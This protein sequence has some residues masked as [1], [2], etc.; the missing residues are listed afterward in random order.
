M[1]F[2][3]DISSLRLVLEYTRKNHIE[4]YIIGNGT[5]L[6]INECF[7]NKIF[8]NLKQLNKIECLKNNK[9]LILAGCTCPK[10]ACELARKG[11]VNQEFLS[12][13]PGS[14][15]G[16]IYMNA[17]AYGS[18]VSK[19]IDSVIILDKNNKI[20]LIKNTKCEFG[21]RTS[22]FKKSKEVIVGAIFNL[23]KTNNKTKAFEKIRY[24]TSNKK[25]IQPLN[26]KSAG[27]AFTNPQELSAW[28]LVENLGYKGKKRGGAKVSDKHS[29]FLINQNHATFNDIYELMIEITLKAK[30]EY[31]IELECEWEIIK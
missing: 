4:Y 25:N 29:N 30:K 19:I 27:S 15:G 28:K 3:K 12:V 17:G 14:I 16:A 18:D 26:A 7:F 13:I 9:V 24:Y 10:V 23:C 1:Y 20:K 21:Y 22:V 5:N 8:I 6:L 11:Y 2:P 31:N